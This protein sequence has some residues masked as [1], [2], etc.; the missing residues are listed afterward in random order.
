MAIIDSTVEIEGEEIAILIDREES[1]KPMG[2]AFGKGE[3]SDRPDHERRD[4][5][6]E[7]LALVTNCARRAVRTVRDMNEEDR[8]DNLSLSFGVRIDHEAGAVI[9]NNRATAQLQV[10][11]SW[12]KPENKKNNE[13]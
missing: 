13:T 7:S 9:T 11:M 5:V 1:R 2:R 4:V 12:K 8:P 3:A 10:A 6:G